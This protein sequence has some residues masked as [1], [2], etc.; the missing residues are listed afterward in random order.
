MSAEGLGVVSG[1][2]APPGV[3]RA[4]TAPTDTGRVQLPV[5]FEVV[6]AIYW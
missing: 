5:L 1:V 6:N 4:L 3:P 2:Q